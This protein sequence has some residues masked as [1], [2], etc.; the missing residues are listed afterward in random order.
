VRLEAHD[1]WLKGQ[2]LIKSFDPANLERAVRLLS[3]AADESPDYSPIHSSIVQIANS[4]HFTLPGKFRDL[5]KARDAVARAK[6]A[7]QLDPVDSRAHLCLGWSYALTGE[8]ERAAPSMELARELNPNDP[9]TLFPVAAF[10]AYF[11]DRKKSVALAREAASLSLAPAPYERAYYA[12]VF[13]LAGNFAEAEEAAHQ[14]RDV[15]A[16]MTGWR[17]AGLFHLGRHDEARREGRR[18]LGAIRSRWL[19]KAE[20]S[21]PAIARWFLHLHPIRLRVQWDSL[22]DGIAGASIPI[23]G[24]EHERW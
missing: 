13:F 6:I 19:G 18:F 22:R 2:A 17:A 16:I 24:I 10:W 3:L 4:E 1:R 20:P 23:D 14:I 11:G 8:Y 21:D 5:A 9:G 12:I 15:I 7:V